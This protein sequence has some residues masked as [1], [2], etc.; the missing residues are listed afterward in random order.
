MY[1]HP[2][3]H[4]AMAM[5]LVVMRKTPDTAWVQFK[6]AAASHAELL[7]TIQSTYPA[8]DVAG[9]VS[10]TEE[11]IDAMAPLTPLSGVGALLPELVQRLA[12]ASAALPDAWL[13]TKAGVPK[14]LI[15]AIDATRERARLMNVETAFQVT[16]LDRAPITVAGTHGEFKVCA[17]TGVILTPKAERDPA[18]RGFERVDI[19]E[20]LAWSRAH[21]LSEPTT[22]DILGLR[23]RHGDGHWEDAEEDFRADLLESMQDTAQAA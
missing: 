15:E 14:E 19:A 17:Q 18:Y 9:V 13:A 12:E 7:S 3:A 5:F 20:Y 8:S 6:Q 22:I 23:I 16:P 10:G 2:Q 1:S 4:R 21:G 11:F